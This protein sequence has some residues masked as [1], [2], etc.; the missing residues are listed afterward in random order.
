MESNWKNKT[1]LLLSLVGLAGGAVALGGHTLID[2]FQKGKNV[3]EKQA[4]QLPAKYANLKDAVGFD[5]SGVAELATSAVVH[6]KT[7]TGGN[8]YKSEEPIDPFDFFKGPHFNF[9][10]MPRSGSGS[11][12]ILT[13]DG[14]IVTNNHVVEGANKIEVILN[15]KRTYIAELIG[16]DKNTDLAV[17]KIPESGLQFIKFGNSDHVKC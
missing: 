8:A 11:G 6:I 15:D 7:T 2:S 9:P 3:S 1:W 13:A 4:I 12:V 17:I 10:N 14:Y 5:F 16:T